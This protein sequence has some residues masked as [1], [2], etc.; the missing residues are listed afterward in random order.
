MKPIFMTV[1]LILS[2]A[3]ASGCIHVT[4][5]PPEAATTP[6]P[7][8][9]ETLAKST[10]SWDGDAL[11]PYPA[12]QP[13]IT[14]LRITIPPRT[15]LPLHYHPVIN[16]GVLLEGQ[17]TVIAEHGK[18]LELKAGDPIVEL[19]STPH[20]GIN[21]GDQPAVIIVFYAATEGAPFTKVTH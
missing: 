15:R 18:R 5:K 12:G 3:G 9:V 10:R 20:Y 11:P 13:E 21:E 7:Y 8:A 14:I 17:L 2:L 16:A 19:V 4:H 6:P 1:G